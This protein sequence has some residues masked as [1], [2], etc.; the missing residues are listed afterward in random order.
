MKKLAAIW[1]VLMLSL[2]VGC[3]SSAPTQEEAAVTP[4]RNEGIVP[5]RRTTKAEPESSEPSAPADTPYFTREGEGMENYLFSNQAVE[6]RLA[7]ENICQKDL[8][9]GEESVLFSLEKD[10]SIDLYLVGVTNRRLYF[11]WKQTEEWWGLQVYSVDYQGKDR[12]NFEGDWRVNQSGGWLVFESFHTDVSQV[13]MILIDRDDKVVYEEPTYSVWATT[14]V[15]ESVYYV[16]IEDVPTSNT[17][18]AVQ[19]REDWV[20]DL[21]RIDADGTKTVLKSFYVNDYYTPVSLNQNT[22]CFFERG[23]YYDLFTLE[24]VDPPD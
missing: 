4:T 14:V 13:K 15:D 10:D 12:Q 21:I 24:P 20:Y 1:L 23:E 11:G 8:S 2:L 17:F 7:G 22:I 18:E 6:I 5:T 9:T 19:A 16:Y 3:D